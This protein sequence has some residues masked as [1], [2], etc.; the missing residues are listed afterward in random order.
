M[1]NDPIIIG[2]NSV[3]L[4]LILDDG[5]RVALL[6]ED[7]RDPEILNENNNCVNRTT[8]TFTPRSCT[9]QPIAYNPKPGFWAKICNIMKLYSPKEEVKQ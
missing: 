3:S 7:I 8:L 6:Y 5:S 1:K 9:V 4:E 2:V